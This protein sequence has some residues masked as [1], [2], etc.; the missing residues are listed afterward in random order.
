MACGEQ[1][2]LPFALE[3]LSGLAAVAAHGNDLSRAARLWGAAGAHRHGLA[4]DRV[5]TRLEA[6]YIQPTRRRHGA[7][8]WD[9]AVREGAALG[10]RDAIA[11]ALEEL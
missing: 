9:A 7:D 2:A 10:F 5:D 11:Y 4:Q 8:A 3:G 1:V 6:A